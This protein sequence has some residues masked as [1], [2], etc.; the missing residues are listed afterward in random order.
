[1]QTCV[2]REWHTDKIPIAN[3]GESQMIR[4]V[5]SSLPTFRQAYFH[6]GFNVVLA[7]R[8]ADSD[9]HDSTNGLG[10]TTLLRI[11]QFCL[12]ADPKRDQLLRHESMRGITFGLDLEIGTQQVAVERNTSHPDH[13]LVSEEFLRGRNV[14]AEFENGKGKLNEGRWKDMLSETFYPDAFDPATR[15]FTPSFRELSRYLVRIGKESYIEPLTAYGGQAG[16]DKKLCTSFLMGLNW[17]TQKE[18][19]DDLKSRRNVKEAIKAIEQVNERGKSLGEM[20]AERVALEESVRAKRA[21]VE[22]FNVREDYRELEHRLNQLDRAIHEALNANHSDHRLLDF[23]NQS[24]NAMPHAR[25]GRASEVF[26]EARHL[27]REEALQEIDAVVKFHDDVYRN[28][29]A[30]L[31]SEVRKLRSR[32]TRRDDQID[33]LSSSK[34]ELLRVLKNSG[35]IETLL[36][37]QSEYRDLTAN[38]EV[39]KAKIEDRRRFERREDE[40]TAALAQRRAVMKRD[41]VD[42]QEKVDEIRALFA[43]YTQVLYGKPGKLSVDVA[44][45]GYATKFAIEKQG[46]D[47]VEQMVLFS[48]DLA[49]ASFWGMRSKGF[50]TLIHD[51]TLFADVDPRQYAVALKLAQEESEKY[52]FQYVAC[53]NVGSIPFSDLGTFGLQPYVQLRLHDKDVSG[54]LLGKQITLS[55]LA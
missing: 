51:S 47:G 29:A 26:E 4:G 19:Q 23:Y 38:L 1:M 55:S 24:A 7:D 50:R 42:R 37:L 8:A 5:C 22:A 9:D 54:R 39:M 30:F 40:L 6:A 31:Q 52:G 45:E 35:A 17:R 18:L 32:I 33:G 20:E 2:D 14:D 15:S 13:V 11:I 43:R 3:A 41:L 10:K 53:L 44:Q 12:G 46:S 28:R 25:V 49:L 27:F 48:F 34:Q 36:E 21:E 16:A